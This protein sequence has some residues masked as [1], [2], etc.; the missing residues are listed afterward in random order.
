MAKC[1]NLLPPKGKEM[2]CK[3]HNMI[4][5]KFT[6]S[7]LEDVGKALGPSL[8][9]LTNSNPQS[10]IPNSEFRSLQGT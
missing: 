2:S 8:L 4:P 1:V 7:I 5:P 6:P 3:I 9:D 10:R